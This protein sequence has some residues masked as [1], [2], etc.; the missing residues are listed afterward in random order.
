VNVRGDGRSIGDGYPA[1]SWTWTLMNQVQLEN[2]LIMFAS[3]ADASVE[4]KIRTPAERGRKTEVEDYTA[5]MHRPLF[6]Q[7]K[8]ATAIMHRPLFNQDKTATDRSTFPV[9][10]EIT[11]RFTKLEPR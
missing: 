2:L 3:D 11:V 9:W 1:A 5:I 4:V 7:D 6:N 10:S 8:T